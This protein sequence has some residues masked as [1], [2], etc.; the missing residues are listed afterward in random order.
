MK[1]VLPPL[2]WRLARLEDLSAM[3]R[4]YNESVQ[5]GGYSPTLS[6]ATPYG[7]GL[8]LKEGR[9]NGWPMWVLA[10]ESEIVGW[11]YLRRIV[12][13]GGACG[14]VADLWIYA[15]RAWHGSGVAMLMARHIHPQILRHGFDTL[16]CWI[17]GGNRRSLSLVRGCRLRRWG[18]LPGIVRYGDQT[19]D[20]EIWGVRA[21]DPDWQS[22]MTRMDT[23]YRRLE[24]RARLAGAPV[25]KPA[26]AVDDADLADDQPAEALQ[27]A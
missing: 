1:Q 24:Q 18:V 10:S 23:R 19:S 8:Q 12:W 22:Y 27:T 16:T 17:L 7:L 6:D 25:F 4:I 11:A 13:G 2:E 15:A 20:L 26:C 21:D 14:A 5:G 9:D 3:T